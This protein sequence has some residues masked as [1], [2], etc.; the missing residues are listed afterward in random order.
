LQEVKKYQVQYIYDTTTGIEL[1]KANQS[2]ISYPLHNHTSVYIIGMV[3]SGVVE[4]N[5]NHQILQ[6]E[7]NQTFLILPYMPHSIKA[8]QEYSMI[9]I[10]MSKTQLLLF[11]G[12]T[13][14]KAV[15]GLLEKEEIVKLSHW[16]ILNLIQMVDIL[17]VSIY[18]QQSDR[19]F[20]NITERIEKNPEQQLNIDE[21]AKEASLSKYHFIR[22]FK[23]MMGLTPHQFQIQNRV[24]KAQRLICQQSSMVEVALTTGFYDQSHFI[25]YFGKIVGL[26]PASYQEAYKVIESNVLD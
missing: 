13:I 19:I 24:R 14:K 4:M 5:L 22:R 21:M 23:K 25:R 18:K 10:C 7:Q 15:K 1:I 26:S 9:S 12:D 16:Q 20:T 3:L 11:K 17:L 8:Y 2:S 6:R